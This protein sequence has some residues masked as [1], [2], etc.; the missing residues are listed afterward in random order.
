MAP[1]GKRSNATGSSPAAKRSR[2]ATGAPSRRAATPSA[3]APRPKRPYRLNEELIRAD[4]FILVEYDGEVPESEDSN[5]D[6]IIF[7]PLDVPITP[8]IERKIE[9]HP[10]LS[11]IHKELKEKTKKTCS[12]KLQHHKIYA[13]STSYDQHFR[14]DVV[15]FLPSNCLRL[16][17]EAYGKG[18]VVMV[19]ND[20][21]E[22]EEENEE[23]VEELIQIENE[24]NKNRIEE[25]QSQLE[26]KQR[27]EETLRAALKLK[28]AEI[29]SLKKELEEKLAHEF[30]TKQDQEQV[31]NGENAE[32]AKTHNAAE[33]IDEVEDVADD[34]VPRDEDVG[35]QADVGPCA[36]RVSNGTASAEEGTSVAVDVVQE[37]DNTKVSTAAEATDEDGKVVEDAAAN[38]ENGTPAAHKIAQIAEHSVVEAAEKTDAVKEIEHRAEDVTAFVEDGAP[39]IEEVARIANHFVDEADKTDNADVKEIPVNQGADDRVDVAVEEAIAAVEKIET[40]A[41]DL[42]TSVENGA[43]ITPISQ[44]VAPG[45]EDPVDV[46]G[47][48]ANA[49]VDEDAIPAE[50]VTVE[51]G[52]PI[53]QGVDQGAD[54][55]LDVTEKVDNDVV[56]IVTTDAEDVDAWLV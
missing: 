36:P 32:T 26:E 27:S 33:A 20:A 2:M 29:A 51:D 37:S 17:W 41:E 13:Y 5:E 35:L 18:G 50:D 7:A 14:V 21:E 28:E 48:L 8:E 6:W 4:D 11:P 24:F 23:D 42:T 56:E 16:H 40:Q 34:V 54:D 1:R 44:E 39:V 52:A 30:A 3:T 49:D 31:F 12:L 10:K 55:S 43:P 38:I 15:E 25:L 46:S 9:A 45:A 47:K 22:M 19:D 53:A